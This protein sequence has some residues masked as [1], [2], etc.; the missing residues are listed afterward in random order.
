MPEKIKGGEL[1][2]V[3]EIETAQDLTTD[4]LQAIK[5]HLEE[6][7]IQKDTLLSEYL[8]QSLGIKI[9]IS[10]SGFENGDQETDVKRTKLDEILDDITTRIN[11]EIG[12]IHIK[13]KHR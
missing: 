11:S 2:Q 5:S 4:E 8:S 9:I 7:G 10:E 13:E 12:E 3:H 6:V 1:S